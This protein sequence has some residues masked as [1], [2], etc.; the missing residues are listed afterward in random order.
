MD[1]ET[2]D[3]TTAVNY[4]EI[5]EFPW[6]SRLTAAIATALLA[7]LVI[8]GPISAFAHTTRQEP[9][10]L[11]LIVI[12]SIEIAKFCLLAAWLAWGGSRAVLRVIIVFASLLF[13]CVVFGIAGEPDITQ[14]F[15]ILLL[16]STVLASLI[17]T[18][19]LFG[20]RW[21][22]AA[23]MALDQHPATDSRR[24]LRQFSIVDLLMWTATVAVIAGIIRWLGL[25]RELLNPDFALESLM[26]LGFVVALAIGTL[27]AIWSALTRSPWV[28]RRSITSGALVFGLFTPLWLAML[29]HPNNG[30]MFFALLGVIGCSLAMVIGALLVPRHLGDRVVRIGRLRRALTER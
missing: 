14:A 16:A 4:L 22:S 26:W 5:H 12:A 11:V 25:P 27:L 17:A 7:P 15:S 29:A 20:C 9:G 30:E 2:P 21:L 10:V 13:S 28:I 24:R 23:E 8:D 18:P 6:L 1:D 19:K 3:P